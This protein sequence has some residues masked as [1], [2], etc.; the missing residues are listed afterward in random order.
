LWHV[1]G[2][3]YR[4][5]IL[6]SA[7]TSVRQLEYFLD[8]FPSEFAYAPLALVLVGVIQLFRSNRT[9]FY[10]TLILFL[11]C[12]LY[13][14]NYDIHDID[15]YF[16]LAYIVSAIWIA[17]GAGTLFKMGSNR[18]G[19]VASTLTC[20]AIGLTPLAF[21]NET[22][23]QSDNYTVEDYAKNMF[24]SLEKNALV[25]TY[26]WDYFVS[27]SYYLQL[28]EGYRNDAVVIDKELLRRSWY[29]EQLE[30]QHPQ[31][32]ENSRAEI[33]AFLKELYKFEHDLPYDPVVIEARYQEMIRSFLV[34]NEPIRPVYATPEIEQEFTQGLQRVP[35]GLAFRLY[36]DT[37][38]R[39]ITPRDFVFHPITKSD[40][41]SEAIRNLYAG[42]YCNQGIYLAIR[43]KRD[44]AVE[45]FRKALQVTP[46][47]P[48]A[49]RWLRQLGIEL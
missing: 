43:G 28:V 16:L 37:T 23:D 45:S 42:A 6:S 47:F 44:K 46:G 22:A 10:L 31:L 9:I 17:F 12:L 35:S 36:P 33:N 32:V 24:D 1:T 48:E 11:S 5:W 3:Q 38:Y 18:R 15:S 8:E 13:S 2:K 4:V 26:Q 20:V 39:E 41:Y 19:K 21:H 34:K 30:H 29:F 27:P 25:L 7:E 14:I 40:M 49:L